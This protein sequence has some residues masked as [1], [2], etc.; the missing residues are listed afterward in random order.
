M[1]TLS[2]TLTVKQPIRLNHKTGEILLA[3]VILARSTSFLFSKVALQTMTP[4]NLIAVRFLLAFFCL[5]LLFHK[6]LFPIQRDALL[7]G[8]VLGALFFAVMS[9]ELF[10]LKSTP[11]ATVSLLENTAIVFVPLLVCVL[12]RKAPRL[13]V[14]SSVGVTFLGIALLSLGGSGASPFSGKVLALLAA[15]LYSIAIILTDRFSRQADALVIGIFQVG[16][17]GFFALCAVFLLETPTLPATQPEWGAV[18]TLALV[19]T[20]F[21]YTLQPVAQSHTTAARTGMFCALNPL[22][23][24]L[25]GNIF[26]HEK[27]GFLGF[28]GAALVLLGILLSSGQKE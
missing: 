11:S 6:K 24:A 5:V 21:G 27:L 2:H 19:C 10:S 15:V 7:R 3:A 13:S 9:A 1:Q 25:L 16:F 14:V 18:L 23:A 28:A 8:M 17:I 20:C 26:L 4:L 12:S 22:G